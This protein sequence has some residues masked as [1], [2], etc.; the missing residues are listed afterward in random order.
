MYHHGTVFF[1][2]GKVYFTVSFSLPS[3]DDGKP[4]LCRLPDEK[5]TAKTPPDGK[6][7][8]SRSGSDIM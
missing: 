2:D 6:L 8:I 7:A 5:L 4:F 1:S 3:I